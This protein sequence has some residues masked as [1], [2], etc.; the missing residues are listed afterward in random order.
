MIKCYTYKNKT[1]VS[2]FCLAYLALT[3]FFT[4]FVK[5]VYKSGATD[6]F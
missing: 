5:I 4:K 1:W 2:I 6:A 3:S